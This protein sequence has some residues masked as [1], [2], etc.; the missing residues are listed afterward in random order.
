MLVD[1]I[2]DE[3]MLHEI[4]R[5]QSKKVKIIV[6]KK[7]VSKRDKIIRLLR[8]KAMRRDD[9][10]K[11][12]N[13]DRSTIYSIIKKLLKEEIVKTFTVKIGGKGRPNVYFSL[14]RGKKEK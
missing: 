4:R 10:V 12:L 11:K 3:K 14:I 5:N 1:V 6:P 13:I 7:V 9:L 8:R 2:L